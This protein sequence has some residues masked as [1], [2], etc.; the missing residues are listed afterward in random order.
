MKVLFRIV[1]GL[2]GVAFLLG[3]ATK[4]YVFL[5]LQSETAELTPAF[6]IRLGIQ[7]LLGIAFVVYALRG[8][9]EDNGPTSIGFDQEIPPT[10]SQPYV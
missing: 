7:A 1:G 4:L 3:C 10:R 2:L 8:R 5:F 6:L 9:S